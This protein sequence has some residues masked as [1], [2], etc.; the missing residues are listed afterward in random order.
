MDRLETARLVI[1]PFAMTDLTAAHQLLD[2]DIHWSG[3]DITLE[4]RRERLQ[5]EINL[6]Q[7]TDTGGRFG[8]RAVVLKATQ[9]I[10]GIC[11]FLPIL[12]TAHERQLFC[13][14]LFGEAE[15]LNGFA[16][17]DLEVGYA[18]GS[19]HRQQGYATEAIFALLDYAFS[20]LNVERVF[21][22][23][24]RSNAGSIALMQRVGMRIAHN[25]ER[26]D[27]DWPDG[28]GVMGVIENYLTDP[29]PT[30]RSV[31]RHTVEQSK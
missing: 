1:R 2:H 17:F 7:W 11:G 6:A 16:A 18:L 28:P 3:P 27:E 9:E 8:Y 4:Q 26:L 15:P 30:P 25:P 31:T 22:T 5:R 10:I 13:H 29:R 19:Q 23:T 14:Q 20:E 21:A 24:N 12:H